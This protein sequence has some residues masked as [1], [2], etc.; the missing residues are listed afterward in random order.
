MSCTALVPKCAWGLP[1]YASGI[2]P[3]ANWLTGN[4]AIHECINLQDHKAEIHAIECL[5]GAFKLNIIFKTM[6]SPYSGI[7]LCRTYASYQKLGKVQIDDKP[8]SH[9]PELGREKELA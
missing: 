3:S 6:P 1:G 4:E 5:R 7:N 9:H 2:K 8:E